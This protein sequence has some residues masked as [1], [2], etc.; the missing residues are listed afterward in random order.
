M[1]AES[2]QEAQQYLAISKTLKPS[3]RNLSDT[4]ELKIMNLGYNIHDSA[5]EKTDPKYFCAKTVLG[6]ER[7]TQDTETA[8]AQEAASR[9]L[10]MSTEEAKDILENTPYDLSRDPNW[11]PFLKASLLHMLQEE[12]QRNP[13]ELHIPERYIYM[14]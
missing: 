7:K 14:K 5:L 9:E 11:P 2:L 10:R 1:S 12:L 3:D 6:L 8:P 4:Q 13:L